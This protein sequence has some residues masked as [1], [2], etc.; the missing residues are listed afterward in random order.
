MNYNYQKD[1][2]LTIYA[3]SSEAMLP[4]FPEFSVLITAICGR[5][6]GITPLFT[7]EETFGEG[8]ELGNM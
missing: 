2:A 1:H 8:T 3:V 6:A 7:K 4:Y 5:M